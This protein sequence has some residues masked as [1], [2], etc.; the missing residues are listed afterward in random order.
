MTESKI[1]PC[2]SEEC[3][4]CD[5]RPRWKIS[6]H[7]VQH[8][9]YEREI[10]AATQEEALRIFEAGTA[11]PSSYDDRGGTIIQ[12]DD[13]IVAQLPPS[14]YH[15]EECCFHDVSSKEMETFLARG[16]DLDE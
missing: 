16:G 1:E 12:Q 15:L 14:R 6:R 10:K 11:W 8:I 7:R 9:T 5:P 2:G 4:R 13:P 3:D